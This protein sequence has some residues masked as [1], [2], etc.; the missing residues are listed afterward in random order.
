M[1]QCRSDQLPENGAEFA[2]ETMRAQ[3]L[4]LTPAVEILHERVPH[5]LQEGE[6]LRFLQFLVGDHE[7]GDRTVDE[8]GVGL[9]SDGVAEGGVER[10]RVLEAFRGDRAEL[11]VLGVE[12]RQHGGP[13]GNA[14][15][16]DQARIRIHRAGKGKFKQKYGI[17]TLIP[18]SS[19]KFS[20]SA[21]RTKRRYKNPDSRNHEKLLQGK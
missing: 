17:K 19:Q 3:P 11:G 5:A 18:L 15:V 6:S 12:F 13:L 21:R 7:I 20:C 1:V 8:E 16:E 4:H 9:R 14:A 2:L 10:R